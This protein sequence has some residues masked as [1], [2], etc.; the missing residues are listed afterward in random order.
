M[1]SL[2]TSSPVFKITIYIFIHQ[3]TK[4]TEH[5][6][7]MDNRVWRIFWGDGGYLLCLVLFYFVHDIKIALNLILIKDM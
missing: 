7:V 3:A 5:D 6:S 4:G 2:G 1:I